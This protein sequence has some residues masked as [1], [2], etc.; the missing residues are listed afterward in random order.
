MVKFELHILLN[1]FFQDKYRDIQHWL[2]FKEQVDNFLT[3]MRPM[4]K[5]SGTNP[6]Y[7]VNDFTPIIFANR[8]HMPNW[9]H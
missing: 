4:V 2:N 3:Q 9:G 1:S 8:G 7:T 5:S 6:T